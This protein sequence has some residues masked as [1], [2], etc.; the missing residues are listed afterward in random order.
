MDLSYILN[1]LGENRGEYFNAMAPPVMQT[2]NFVFSSVEEMRRGLAGEADV[3]VY[4][5][6]VNPTV[7]V[8]RQKMAA[9]EGAED[10]LVFASG[11]GAVA[12]AVL[13][14][15]SGGGH[16]VSV[17]DPYSWTKGL[18]SK[19]LPQLGVETTFVDGGDPREF[20]GAIREN[21]ELIYL[22]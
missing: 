1:H 4:S 12:A 3:A 14:N 6:G 22:E 9:L 5:R 8:L 10:A 2:S 17:R 15:V 19:L 21:E 18:F 7:S 16:V 13:S 20:A 11:M